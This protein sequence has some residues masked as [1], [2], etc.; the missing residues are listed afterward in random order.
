MLGLR[1]RL[2]QPAPQQSWHHSRG[3]WQ[4]AGERGG[5]I[6]RD[7]D[8]RETGTSDA[9]FSVTLWSNACSDASDASLSSKL[10]RCW[11]ARC[12]CRRTWCHE[13]AVSHLMLHTV[14][15]QKISLC[16]SRRLEQLVIRVV[17]AALFKV[18]ASNKQKTVE[19]LAESAAIIH[20]FTMS[21]PLQWSSASK[22]NVVCSARGVFLLRRRYRRDRTHFPLRRTARTLSRKITAPK[23]ATNS[24]QTIKL[25]LA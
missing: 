1:R 18:A 3:E 12:K 24:K 14:V 16:S 4:A 5:T 8:S 21:L 10:A 15:T 20:G 25:P 6:C 23:K 2:G 13:P 11:R 19:E 7:A 22:G 9:G 17:N